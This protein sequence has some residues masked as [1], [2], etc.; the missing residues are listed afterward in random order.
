MNTT[1]TTISRTRTASAIRPGFQQSLLAEWVKTRSVRSTGFALLALIALTFGVSV[2][3]TSESST[4]CA[5]ASCGDDD[6]VAYTLFGAF[7]GQ[8]GAI[9]LGVL[10]ISSEY[11]S[12]MI[13]SS[14]VANPRR[15]QVFAAKTVL[16]AALVLIASTIAVLPSF[17]LGISLLA[18]N[19]YSPAHGYPT[20]SLGE[21]DVFRAVAGTIA[22]L[23]L[24]AV[25]GL[26]IGTLVR[27]TAGG[28]SAALGVVFVP[29]ITTW[30]TPESVGNHIERWSPV[31]AG[32]SIQQTTEGGFATFENPWGGLALFAAYTIATVFAAGWSLRQRD[33]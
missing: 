2:L 15:I 9:V 25:L 31:T 6:I 19:G 7:V 17:F 13:R 21:M 23:V 32:L 18:G 29:L 16:L 12:G 5:S 26:G 33:A 20:P 22:Y 24:V 10:A 30:F 4:Q 14:F 8:I 3:I 28:S 27:G 1:L 11:D